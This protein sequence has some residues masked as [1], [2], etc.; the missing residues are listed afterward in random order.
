ME[1]KR[2]FHVSNLKYVQNKC[3]KIK[4][5]QFPVPQNDSMDELDIH[6]AAEEDFGDQ[7]APRMETAASTSESS[8]IAARQLSLISP[9]PI[10]LLQMADAIRSYNTSSAQPQ[11]ANRTARSYNTSSVQS[12]GANQSMAK[13]ANDQ[14]QQTQQIAQSQPSSS[15]GLRGDIPRPFKTEAPE[16]A[17]V[18][19]HIYL[20]YPLDE[21]TSGSTLSPVPIQSTIIKLRGGIQDM[22]STTVIHNLL[23]TAEKGMYDTP[24]IKPVAKHVRVRLAGRFIWYEVQ[25]R[26]VYNQKDPTSVPTPPPEPEI[27]SMPHTYAFTYK[28]SYVLNVEPFPL[29][30]IIPEEIRIKIELADTLVGMANATNPTAAI[31]NVIGRI[32][33]FAQ[34]NSP[35]AAQRFKA[36]TATQAVVALRGNR[37]EEQEENPKGKQIQKRKQISPPSSDSSTA[38]N[39]H[40]SPPKERHQKKKRNKGSKSSHSAIEEDED[41]PS[42]SHEKKQASGSKK[43]SKQRSRSSSSSTDE[44]DLRR[45]LHRKMAA[46][47]GKTSFKPRGRGNAPRGVPRKWWK[48]PFQ[49][50]GPFEPED[51]Y[52][53]QMPPYRHEEKRH[54]DRASKRKD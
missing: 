48:D 49:N 8:R 54:P 45:R 7:E 40:K 12:G 44:E 28:V 18:V 26:M 13:E 22:K 23:K 15:H 34:G 35:K 29:Q 16:D 10:E 25:G 20:R 36:I 21:P 46:S 37:Q 9:M 41:K 33:A 50:R 14:R 27:L 4:I 19:F 53:Y 32:Q 47:R 1:Q 30:A 17:S 3:L 42:T 31:N 43:P 38:H 51:A 5:A 52:G 2:E 24:A 11:G 6:L 39:P